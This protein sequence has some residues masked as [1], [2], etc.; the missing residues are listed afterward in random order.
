VARSV[1]CMVYVLES[2]LFFWLSFFFLG[3]GFLFSVL[4]LELSFRGSRNCI[5]LDNLSHTLYTW[6]GVV[7]LVLHSSAAEAL[8]GINLR[9]PLRWGYQWGEIHRM[10]I[11]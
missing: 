5:L 10:M 3:I 8:R 11:S 4:L 2:F 9:A 7:Q 6:S 1:R